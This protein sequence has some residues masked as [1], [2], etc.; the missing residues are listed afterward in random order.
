M[1]DTDGVEPRV[2]L[3]W[4]EDE[5]SDKIGNISIGDFIGDAGF[6]D[7]RHNRPAATKAKQNG[8]QFFYG[9]PCGFCGCNLRHA[10]TLDCVACEKLARVA[11]VV[12]RRV[13][14]VRD[15]KAAR[16]L[17]DGNFLPVLTGRM[18][19]VARRAAALVDEQTYI[20]KKCDCGN[21]K[22]YTLR[23]QCVA[24][25]DAR[26]KSRTKK[27]T[28]PAQTEAVINFDALFD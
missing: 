5:L 1:L 26:N 15:S 2:A 28:A 16:D 23:G 22:R 17:I 21:S 20:G 14:T 13:C 25:V 12:G 6:T 18:D 4:V 3:K 19:M 9:S 8:R 10:M 24:C 7:A 11:T 27:K